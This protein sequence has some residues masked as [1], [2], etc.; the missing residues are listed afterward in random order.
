MTKPARRPNRRERLAASAIALV[1]AAW[2]AAGGGFGASSRLP[3]AAERAEATISTST[4]ARHI[5]ELADDRLEGRG[6]GHAGNH[7]AER[8]LD[9]ALTALQLEPGAG[10]F[11]QPFT[12]Y[13]TELNS[14]SSLT[15]TDDRSGRTIASYR[16]GDDFYP[17]PQSAVGVAAGEAAF[18]GYGISAPAIGYDDYAHLDVR[19]RIVLVLD[20]RPLEEQR[21]TR[22]AARLTGLWDLETKI[23]AARARGAAGLIVI[24]DSHHHRGGHPF[25]PMSSA[26]PAHPSVRQRE[27]FLAEDL[28]V[29]KLVVA[30]MSPGTAERLL[31]NTPESASIEELQKKIDRALAEASGDRVDAPASFLVPSRRVA[32]DV[33]LARTPVVAQNVIGVVSGS[34]PARRAELIV[35]GAHFDHDGRDA[36]RRIYNGAD[37]NASGTAAVLELARAFASASHAG[38][39]PRRSVV[40]ALWNAEEKGSLGSIHYARHPI[41]EGGTV[42]ANL[43]LDM[44]GRDEDVPDPSDPRFTGLEKTTA[45]ANTNTLHVLG[46]SY[47]PGMAALVDEENAAIGLFIEKDYDDNAQGLIGRS[48]QWS[49]LERRIPALFFT[50]GLH[51]DYH[52]PQDDAGKIN[53]P[54]LRKIVRLAYRVAWRLA[55]SDALPGFVEPGHGPDP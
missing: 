20:H 5:R 26:W 10:H 31:S 13:S 24:P 4:L 34:D 39:R 30:K 54:K 47:A 42:V 19:G 50:T 21:P 14:V 28:D 1:S 11:V 18:A 3:E 7:L 49:F 9:S 16:P 27:F 32:I 38:P 17:S 55:D 46:Y 53:V 25:P 12:L 15:F 45:T 35:I 44:V 6:V 8:Y 37:D 52:T 48:D 51:P 23:A 29:Q 2:Y 40:F 41:P 36:D 33:K 43:N 22:F